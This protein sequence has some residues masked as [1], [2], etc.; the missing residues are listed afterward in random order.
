MV[1][2]P[3]RVVKQPSPS[4]KKTVLIT[5]CS[6]GG[7]GSALALAFHKRG[8]RV[9]ATARNPSKMSHLTALGIE[10]LTL[11]VLS[12]SSISACVSSVTSLTGGSLDILVNNS[13]AGYTMPLSDTDIDDARQCFEL[14]VW[15]VLAVTQAFLPLLL[16]S[17]QGAMV[18]NNT[19]IASVTPVPMQG[20][21]NASK[22]AAA[23]LTDNLRIELAPFKVKVVDLRT[24]SVAS[25]IF[26][27]MPTRVLPKDSIYAP[28]REVVEE[29]MAGTRLPAAITA[30]NW[31]EQVAR[32]LLAAKPPTHVWRGQS[33]WMVWFIK[34]F[35]P[36]TFPDGILAKM[37]GL[38]VLEEKLAHQGSGRL[39][40]FSRIVARIVGV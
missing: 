9:F 12:A 15:A 18:V 27:N 10:T 11:D 37:G 23:M 6:E 3:V 17:Q 38:N 26:Q 30:E 36:Y 34:R 25:N 40:F 29:A 2:P 1:L 32:D 28:A 8:L 5:G 22:A 13:G 31:A 24:G 33:A 35:L 20:I 7:L 39:S 19:S 16:N 14:N 4:S 21:Y